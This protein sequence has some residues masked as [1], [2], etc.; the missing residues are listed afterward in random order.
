MDPAKNPLLRALA[1]SKTLLGVVHLE[2]LPG[3]PRS[4]G[5]IGEAIAAARRDAERILQAGFDG[6]IFEN[7]GDAPFFA[8]EVPPWVVA[9]MARIA[10]ELPRSGA[11]VGVNVLRNDA[12]AALGI[13]AACGLP[14]FR[15]NVHV[16]AAVT[17]QGL[18]VGRA[19]RIARE[20][21]A[22]GAEVAI[23]ADVDVKHGSPLGSRFD[24]A[25]AARET[26]YRGLADALVVTGPET[27]RPASLGDL[28]TVRDAV[29]DRPLLAGSGA[30]AE[31][32]R[33]ILEL[34]DGVIVGS[35]IEEGGRA[36]RPVDPERARRF[37]EAARR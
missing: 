36:G 26:A 37:V 19:A 21:K 15:T 28:R 22:L 31:T 29:P 7:F 11:L 13:A 6:Y 17:D 23:V 18:I 1:R 16:G 12:L 9:A 4:R 20:R 3:S 30:T 34:A 8:D 25:S 10:A 14:F 2:P 27:G 33:E 32:V 35:A 5:G 24:L